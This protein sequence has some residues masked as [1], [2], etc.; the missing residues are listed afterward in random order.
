ME[1]RG[2]Q[3]EK[4]LNWPVFDHHDQHFLD[5]EGGHTQAQ[6]KEQHGGTVAAG[7]GLLGQ[8]PD[9]ETHKGNQPENHQGHGNGFELFVIHRRLRRKSGAP[10]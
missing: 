2:K 8:I 5:D 4:R 7:L 3:P 9:D 10:V 1:Q 6:R